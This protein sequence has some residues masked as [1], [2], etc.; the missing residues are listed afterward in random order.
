MGVLNDIG[1]RPLR[2][3]YCVLI[4]QHPSADSNDCRENSHD[5]DRI[6]VSNNLEVQFVVDQRSDNEDTQKGARNE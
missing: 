3:I 4:L 1:E 2:I 6:E 5:S